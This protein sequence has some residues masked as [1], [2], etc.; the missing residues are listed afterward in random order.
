MFG[1]IVFIIV[2]IIFCKILEIPAARLAQ[3]FKRKEIER[4]IELEM[5]EQEIRDRYYSDYISRNR[6]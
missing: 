6:K 4:E 5:N 1:L 3:Y 2:F